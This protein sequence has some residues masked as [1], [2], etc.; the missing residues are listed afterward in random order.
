MVLPVFPKVGLGKNCPML[1]VCDVVPRVRRINRS[2]YLSNLLT[3]Y[4][5]SAFFFNSCNY[6]K[7]FE[8]QLYMRKQHT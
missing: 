5:L 3:N 4:L 8:I 2:N 7:L 1:N 6:L